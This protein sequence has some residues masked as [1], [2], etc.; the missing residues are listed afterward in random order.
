[1][2]FACASAIDIAGHWEGSG[3]LGVAEVID[4]L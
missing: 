2:S 4:E 1:M 3:R